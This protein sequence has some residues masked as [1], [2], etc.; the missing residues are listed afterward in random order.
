MKKLG[1]HPLLILPYNPANL[2]PDTRYQAWSGAGRIQDIR[3]G[4]QL[5]IQMSTG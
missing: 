4:F 2:K 1:M 3:P 5:N